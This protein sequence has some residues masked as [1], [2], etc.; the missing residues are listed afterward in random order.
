MI[1]EDTSCGECPL[2][3]GEVPTMKQK[4]LKDRE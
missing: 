1:R 4:G 2:F 3:S